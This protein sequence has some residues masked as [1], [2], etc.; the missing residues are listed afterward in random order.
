MGLSLKPLLCPRSIA[1]IGASR[2]RDSIG[3][4]VL[5]NLL[6]R[7]FQGPVYPVNPNATHIQSVPAYA[8]IEDVPGE[9]DLAII[10]VPAAAV[11]EAA[12]AC[13]KKG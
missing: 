12:E 3:G 10:V 2:R 9:V 7:P 1:V 5:H 11:L 6:Q 13:G 8:S 4:A